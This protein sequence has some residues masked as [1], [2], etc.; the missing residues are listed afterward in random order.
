MGNE[1]LRKK[2]ENIM[3]IFIRW[4]IN[5]YIFLV[6]VPCTP[7]TT[8]E[9]NRWICRKKTKLEHYGILVVVLYSSFFH[10]ETTSASV[11][12]LLPFQSV[13]IHKI[14]EAKR[15]GE[16]RQERKMEWQRKFCGG[17]RIFTLNFPQGA[18]FLMFLQN[19]VCIQSV[20]M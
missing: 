2:R 12:F 4:Q 7:T 17:K 20:W 16:K 18:S 11:V 8:T 14:T 15:E 1:D 13:A 10:F 3:S 19:N 9:W 6:R 5:V